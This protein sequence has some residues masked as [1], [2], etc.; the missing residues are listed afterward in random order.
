VDFSFFRMS[1]P[2]KKYHFNSKRGRVLGILYKMGVGN[3]I[4]LLIGIFGTS[5]ELIT[6]GF[7]LPRKEVMINNQALLHFLLAA[8]TGVCGLLG[9]VSRL[10]YFQK[11]SMNLVII[12]FLL[13]FGG[14]FMVHHQYTRF[15]KFIHETV[16]VLIIIAAIF[17][18]GSEIYPKL[19][20][21]YVYFGL[22]ASL[23]A[24]SV[25]DYFVGSMRI[26]RF[27][28]E[29]YAFLMANLSLAWFVF[30][31]FVAWFLSKKTVTGK[32]EYELHELD[33]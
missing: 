20:L 3:V 19:T 6:A 11:K 4:L 18:I 25:S 31:C 16:G 12:L 28:P 33:E 21:I 24:F 7:Y 22:V 8:Y 10:G 14:I 2:K 32:Q 13:G 9:M 27:E 1:D 30:L 5:L 15:D 17:K 23:T 29:V 26:L